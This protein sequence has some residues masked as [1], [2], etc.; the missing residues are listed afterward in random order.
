MPATLPAR[1][2]QT[3]FRSG[4]TALP[5]LNLPSSPRCSQQ[6]CTRRIILQKAR[7]HPV[8]PRLTPRRTSG[9]RLLVGAGFQ[10]LFHPPL[11]VLF[12]FPSRYSFPVGR[13]WSLALEGGPPSFPR[14]FACPVVLRVPNPGPPAR[15]LRG[16]HPLRRTFP[17]ASADSRR[18]T[19]QVREPACATPRRS[20]LQPRPA[21]FP[22][23]P[24][25]A[26]PGSLATTTGISL[27]FSSSGY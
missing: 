20:S 8:P 26:P 18:H 15:R 7:R 5:P 9:L 6:P 22:P 3:R 11:G 25:W 10:G 23:P 19:R 12:T 21:G 17:G 27:D 1:P 4:S 2:V 24:V 14:D 13:Q 16:S